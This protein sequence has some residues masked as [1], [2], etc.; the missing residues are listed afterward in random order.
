MQIWHNPD[1]KL[2]AESSA[3][4]GCSDQLLY[5]GTI[6][7]FLLK[8]FPMVFLVIPLGI[9]CLRGGGEEIKMW[10][11]WLW[12]LTFG[13]LFFFLALYFSSRPIKSMLWQLYSYTVIISVVFHSLFSSMLYSLWI[14]LT[15][16]G[17]KGSRIFLKPLCCI[18]F[19][20]LS[21]PFS[22]LI[23]LQSS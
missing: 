3:I 1:T 6:I 5:T 2:H 21:V 8:R 15:A 17:W 4:Q 18:V 10:D 11:H 14:I 22:L 23:S 12:L 7:S 20:S 9:Y 16:E 13:W 19:V